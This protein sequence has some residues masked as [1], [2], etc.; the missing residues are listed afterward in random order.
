MCLYTFTKCVFTRSL[1]VS[2]HVHYYIHVHS[3]FHLSLDPGKYPFTN[4]YNPHFIWVS[5]QG[6]IRSPTRTLH[7]SSESRSREVSVHQHVQS[8]FTICPH[9]P[10]PSGQ[11]HVHGTSTCLLCTCLMCK[12][13]C[14]I[15]GTLNMKFMCYCFCLVLY[16]NID[17]TLVNSL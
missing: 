3:T 11:L 5:I 1:S 14:V 10:F 2:L 9:C 16:T 6:S 4:T 7:I 17:Q 8:T 15:N 12:G 13:T